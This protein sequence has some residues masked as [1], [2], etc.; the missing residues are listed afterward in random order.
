MKILFITRIS[1]D[2]HGGAGGAGIYSHDVLN[3]LAA[4]GFDVYVLWLKSGLVE[5]QESRQVRPQGVAYR[6]IYPGSIRIGRTA[7]MARGTLAAVA[8]RLAPLWGRQPAG[9]MKDPA[10]GAPLSARELAYV[11]RV[12]ELGWGAVICNYCWLAP[13][14]DLFYAPTKKL[15]L[16]HDV[17]HEH[18]LRKTDNAHFRNL[19]RTQESAYLKKADIVVAI[20]DRDAATFRQ[21]VPNRTVITALMSC[22]PVTTLSAV[23][24][25]RLLF[26]GSGYTANVAGMNWFLRQV[27]P[28]LET[29]KPGYFELR[30][31]GKVGLAEDLEQVFPIRVSTMG[32]VTDIAAEYGCAEI[33]I[34]PLRE[35][36]GL[37]IKVVE[38]LS[39]G[40]AVLTTPVGAQGLEKLTGQAFMVAQDA[41]EFARMLLRLTGDAGLRSALERG[42]KEAAKTV[43]SP[44]QSCKELREALIA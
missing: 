42:A 41:G 12:V 40:K 23:V 10:W 14:L 43:L 27:A 29:E 37:K 17:W 32:V 8:R 15:V 5:N 39:Y 31:V 20:T 26:V 16:A 35:G 1:P 28:L 22:T 13:A 34:A 19:D 24:P 25:G 44:A 33:I 21:M 2:P 4:S 6:M 18:V 38:A 7:W 11:G 36:T 30:L 9:A 3:N